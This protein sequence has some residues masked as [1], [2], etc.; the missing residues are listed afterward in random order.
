MKPGNGV[1]E[2]ILVNRKRSLDVSVASLRH[3]K[4]WTRGDG[5]SD[6]EAT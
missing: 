3:G 1:E 5:D 6:E 2:K 4:S